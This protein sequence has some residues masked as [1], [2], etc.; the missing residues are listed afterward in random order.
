MSQ[1]SDPAWV[2]P[3]GGYGTAGGYA[4][5]P[6]GYS[7]ANSGPTLVEGPAPVLVSFAPPAKQN[8]LTIAFRLLLAVPHV[9]ILYALDIAAEVVA[10]IGWFAALFT[11]SL[12]DWAHTFIT[13][14]LRW[15]VRISAYTLFL[16][17]SYPPFS[18]EDEPYPVRLVTARARLNRF[19]VFFRLILV[20][21]AVVVAGVAVYGVAVVSFF[22]WLIALIA[23]RLP[24]SLHQAIAA[25]LRFQIRFTS[26][27][28]L[29]TGVYP[30]WGLFGDHVAV[31]AMAP[32]PADDADTTPAAATDPWR[33]PLSAA[34]Q[35]LVALFLVLGVAA[36]I[37]LGFL[38]SSA[39]NPGSAFSNARSLVLIGSAYN[40]VA[41]SSTKF[42]NAVQAC[43]SLSCVTAQ[44]SN[45]ATA[46]RA[47]ASA[48]S[49]AGV[50]GSAS[51][52]ANRLVNDANAAAQSLDKLAA[53]TTVAQYQSEVS[54]TGLQQQLN[55]L[56][57]DY[58]KL[59][60]DLRSL[61]A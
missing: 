32:G 45:E 61:R 51:A 53:S 19:A 9:I 60:N 16:T 26:Y 5:P 47:F 8:R 3:P 49:S 20:I 54:A 2:A 39:T 43:G 7:P 55:S 28:Y 46:L 13:G 44:D 33:L 42:E 27:F 37:V 24:E 18:L 57:A 38:A 15:Q 17:G 6:G 36:L 25:V 59:I 4:G 34:A 29:V 56:D 30:W 41:S 50:T 1:P 12:P 58:T 48:V 40:K 11:G 23:G 52:D 35:G 14:V 31:P 10:I 21:P 22:C